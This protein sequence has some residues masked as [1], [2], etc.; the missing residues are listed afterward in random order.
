MNGE[1]YI[2][3]IE[4][5]DHAKQTICKSEIDEYYHRESVQKLIW[6]QKEELH[7]QR[8]KTSIVSTST[9]GKILLWA[10]EDKF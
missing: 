4:E 5:K 7:G 6:I 8:I 2:W 9:D 3:N 10:L 1:I